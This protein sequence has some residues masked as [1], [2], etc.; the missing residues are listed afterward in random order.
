MLVKYNPSH[1]NLPSQTEYWHPLTQRH[2]WLSIPCARSSP[3][4]RAACSFTTCHCRHL[5]GKQTT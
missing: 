2:A 5:T 3:E 1:P 4:H